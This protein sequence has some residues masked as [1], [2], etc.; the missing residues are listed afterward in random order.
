MSEALQGPAGNS[1]EI[2]ITRAELPLF[3]PRDSES[4]WSMH[5]RVF[6][7]IE[8]SVD[9]RATCP[10]CGAKYVLVD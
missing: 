9:Q 1:R 8:D 5:P 4:A 3:C 10:Y 6:I 2:E 7:P